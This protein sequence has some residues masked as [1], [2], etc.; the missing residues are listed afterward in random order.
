M[1]LLSPLFGLCTAELTLRTQRWKSTIP[2]RIGGLTNLGEF[3]VIG[4]WSSNVYLTSCRNPDSAGCRIK[5]D[6]SNGVVW[7][8]TPE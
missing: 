4:G 6:S 7:D 8:S 5:R 1:L 3:F 2:T